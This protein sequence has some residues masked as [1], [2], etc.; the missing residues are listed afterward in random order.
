[1]GISIVFADVYKEGHVKAIWPSCKAQRTKIPPA[2]LLAI[3]GV[4][5]T[6]A[7]DD[8][9]NNRASEW[10]ETLCSESDAN[11][12]GHRRRFPL[13]ANHITYS[14]MG[15]RSLSGSFVFHPAVRHKPFSL[16]DMP[17]CST[18]SL[19]GWIYS[20]TVN[21]PPGPR[22]ANQTA[23]R[24]IYLPPEVWQLLIPNDELRSLPKRPHRLPL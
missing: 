2:C 12:R 24:F 1:M 20:W 18:N 23:A 17:A 19:A 22:T 9:S 8:I 10:A 3:N 13:L 15:D 5:P 7:G 21:R 14:N 16:F 11:Q 4:K 6:I